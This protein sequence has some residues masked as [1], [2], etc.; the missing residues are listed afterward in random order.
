MS[1]NVDSKKAKSYL[2]LKGVSESAKVILNNK[3]IGMKI[4][5][6]YRFDISDYI[7]E[8]ENKLVIDVSTTLV[9]E[10]YDWLSQ[11]MLLEPIGITESIIIESYE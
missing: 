10:Q 5:P 3:E 9:R 2:V 6:P 11:Y 1:F 7:F 8:G 4:V